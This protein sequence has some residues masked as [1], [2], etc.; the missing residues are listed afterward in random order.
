MRSKAPVFLALVAA[1]LLAALAWLTLRCS[2][3]GYSRLLLAKSAAA[4]GLDTSLLEDF[5]KEEFL[6][7]YETEQR[8][9]AQAHHYRLPVTLIG[10]NSCYGQILGYRMLS[11]G[12]FSAAAWQAGNREAVLNAAAAFQLFGGYQVV[13]Q[14]FK[15]EGATWLIIGVLDDGQEET[16]RIYVPA[17]VT[18]G[19]G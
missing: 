14:T 15:L 5:C 8:A 9:T 10:T 13:G 3:E 19:N 1:L 12:F 4:P 17:S 6:L 18:G 2:D 16:P 11:G 7:T